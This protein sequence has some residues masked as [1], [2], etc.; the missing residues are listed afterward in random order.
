MKPE[1]TEFVPVKCDVKRREI[2][3]SRVNS[4]G[5]VQCVSCGEWMDRHNFYP[6][7]G[8]KIGLCRLCKN[9]SKTDNKIRHKSRKDG[10]HIST[11]NQ[12]KH[13]VGQ[14]C[15]PRC[16]EQLDIDNFKGTEKKGYC[17]KCTKELYHI[18]RSNPGHRLMA[19]AGTAEK[20]AK[21]HGWD[22]DLPSDWG[23]TQYNKQLGMCYYSGINMTMSFSGHNRSPYVV[24]I[25][26]IDNKK[27][28]LK[29]NCVLCCWSINAFK[30]ESDIM[31]L[32]N[33]SRALVAEFDRK[34]GH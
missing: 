17:N 15:C 6:S 10:T 22:F 19:I 18:D 12:D 20:R 30:G 4:A 28:Y 33:I 3:T 1:T 29:D 25:D 8:N 34:R 27:G 32:E 7:I 26:R 14:R 23:I 5:K 13:M 16:K 31:S 2:A 21:A 9:C 24:S 11:L